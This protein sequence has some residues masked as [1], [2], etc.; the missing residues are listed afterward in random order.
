MPR[1]DRDLAVE[2]AILEEIS[3]RDAEA[4]WHY[5]ELQ[6]VPS[7]LHCQEFLVA[8]VYGDVPVAML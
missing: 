6:N 5:V 7:H 2:Y 3:H 1:L 4:K 8:L